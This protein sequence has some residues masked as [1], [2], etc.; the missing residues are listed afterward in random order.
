[1]QPQYM[2]YYSCNYC[3]F[4]MQNIVNS[5][6]PTI[7]KESPVSVETVTMDGNQENLSSPLHTKSNTPRPHQ[8][9]KKTR[10]GAAAET[11]MTTLNVKFKKDDFSGGD[12]YHLKPLTPPIVL[13]ISVDTVACSKANKEQK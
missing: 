10:E 4:K 3:C 6:L 11:G 7:P 1:M 13:K 2:A 12:D 9:T 8:K 5:K